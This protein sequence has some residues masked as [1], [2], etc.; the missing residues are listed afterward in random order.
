M[1]SK[2]RITRALNATNSQ[3]LEISPPNGTSNQSLARSALVYTP[4]ATRAL[5]RG[6]YCTRYIPAQYASHSLIPR[7]L[8]IYTYVYATTYLPDRCRTTRSTPRESRPAKVQ[9]PSSPSC[10]SV[11]LA[12]GSA[13]RYPLFASPVRSFQIIY[14][15]WSRSISP[16][17]PRRLCDHF[18][19]FI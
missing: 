14:L 5:D 15:I 11:A 12:S 1:P 8:P 17:P 18:R 10:T 4:L 13:R 3:S 6:V 2:C 9:P 16:Q 7:V 19:S